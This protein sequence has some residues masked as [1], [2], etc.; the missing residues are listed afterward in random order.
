MGEEAFF[1]ASHLLTFSKDKFLSE[2]DKI[3]LENTSNF[4]I[5]M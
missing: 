2:E 4:D 3:R 1:N 5:F